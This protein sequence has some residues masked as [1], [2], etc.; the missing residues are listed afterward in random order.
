MSSTDLVV[1]N[2]TALAEIDKVTGECE[3]ALV[4]LGVGDQLRHVLRR[5]VHVHRQHVRHHDEQR[6]R[7]EVLV[8]VVGHLPVEVRIERHLA[9]R[10]EQRVAVGRGTGSGEQQRCSAQ[11][12]QWMGCFH[13]VSSA[14]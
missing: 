14:W 2:K 6:D 5:H 1:K 11:V 10:D 9:R 3:L 7:L 8:P 4:L 12:R 13:G